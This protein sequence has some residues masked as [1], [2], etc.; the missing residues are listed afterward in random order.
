MWHKQ[1]QLSELIFLGL[2][3]GRGY[4]SNRWCFVQKIVIQR[5]L[6]S[7]G[8]F[9]SA[10]VIFR[11]DFWI[12]QCCAF[13]YIHGQYNIYGASKASYN[14]ASQAQRN[15]AFYTFHFPT[16]LMTLSFSS[17][18]TTLTVWFNVFSSARSQV[19]Y[20]ICEKN[21]KVLQRKDRNRNCTLWDFE[22]PE[23]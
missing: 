1:I 16:L 8:N 21:E 2:S 3:Y 7:T 14:T 22:K 10:S 13:Y 4:F 19:N 12:I 15:L 18:C 9:P 6:E 5:P 11:S 17:S 20:L 23:Q